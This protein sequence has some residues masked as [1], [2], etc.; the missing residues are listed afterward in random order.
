MRPR[1]LKEA[2]QARRRLSTSVRLHVSF[3]KTPLM[4]VQ[5]RGANSRKLSCPKGRISKMI[6]HPRLDHQDGDLESEPADGLPQRTGLMNR[7]R[8]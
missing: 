5:T 2:D 1:R 8:K 3:T 7:A 6:S 4:D